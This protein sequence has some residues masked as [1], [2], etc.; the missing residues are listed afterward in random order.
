MQRFVLPV[1]FLLLAIVAVLIFGPQL[2]ISD[3]WNAVITVF[4]GFA[5]VL[6]HGSAALGWRNLLTF[7]L[8]TIVISFFMEALGVATGWVFGH[9]H[10]TD[11]LGFK[12]LGVPPLIQFAY[13]A[14]GYASLMMARIIMGVEGK[15]PTR[16]SMLAVCVVGTFI[17]VSW[18]VAMDPYQSTV[19]GDWI[20]RDGGP[21]FGIGLHNY[22]GWFVTVFS[23]MF[24]YQ[25][26]ASFYAEQPSAALAQS[27]LF[28]SQPVLYYAAIALSI[29]LVP[30]VGGVSLPYASPGNY[31]G[32]LDSL[33]NSLTVI[34]FF[35]MGT[36]VAIALAKLITKV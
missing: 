33:V 32:T 22:A 36:P 27:R 8:I 26:Y 28:W 25:L 12:L 19:G 15:S 29:I 14:M 3:T 31:S 24:L 21:Y 35:G 4:A 11:A 9:Y 16:W 23:F 6:V 30:W 18:D 20:W 10:Y 34:A 13:V 5:F 2:G 7:L 17:M 1:A